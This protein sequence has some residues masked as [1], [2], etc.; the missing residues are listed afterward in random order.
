MKQ[1]SRRRKSKRKVDSSLSNALTF[2]ANKTYIKS[3]HALPRLDNYHIDAFFEH[4][5]PEFKKYYKPAMCKDE[6]NHMKPTKMFAIINSKNMDELSD[7]AHWTM[8]YLLDP[9]YAIIFDSMG[10]IPAD[11]ILKYVTKVAKKY[12]QMILYSD[13]ELQTIGSDSCGWYCIYVIEQL[14]KGRKFNDILEDFRTRTIRKN[15]QYL[16]NLYKPYIRCMT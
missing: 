12:N 5:Y 7:G 8:I 1:P 9:N 10:A 15:E 14:L 16:Y 2:S 11:P 3:I 4:K 13:T 6:L